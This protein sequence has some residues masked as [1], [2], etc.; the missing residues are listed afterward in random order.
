MVSELQATD[1]PR[2]RTEAL[3]I[4]AVN[5]DDLSKLTPGQIATIRAL[6]FLDDDRTLEQRLRDGDLDPVSPEYV[7][8]YQEV[9]P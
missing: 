7:R 9:S 3:H 5:E 2:N 4:L 8:D 6:Y 1:I